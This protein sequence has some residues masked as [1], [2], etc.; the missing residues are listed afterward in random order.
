MSRFG[1][2]NPFQNDLSEMLEERAKE[3]GNRGAFM[4]VFQVL[5]YHTDVYWSKGQRVDEKDSD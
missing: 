2:S 1:D 4:E 3:I 5:E